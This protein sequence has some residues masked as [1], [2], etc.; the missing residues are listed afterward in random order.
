M[1][2]SRNVAIWIS[3]SAL[4]LFFSQL[5]AA[6]ARRLDRAQKALRQLLLLENVQR[7]LRGSA[8][9]RH[10]LAQ[11]FRGILARKGEL[12]R[13]KHRVLRELERI[14]LRDAKLHRRSGELLDEP[15]DVGRT[16]RRYGGHRID[17][18]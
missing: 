7:R 12:R 15:K 3:T 6:T 1:L 14:V 5:G 17:E 11:R 4:V 13:S 9:G 18:L 16:A 2:S 10:V 8:L